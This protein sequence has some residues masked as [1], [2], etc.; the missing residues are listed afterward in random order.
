MRS[1]AGRTPEGFL[2]ASAVQTHMPWLTAN[3]PKRSSVRPVDNRSLGAMT[4]EILP[5]LAVRDHHAAG[6]T[7]FL[8]RGVQDDWP[9]TVRALSWV[10]YCSA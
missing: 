6:G 4:P 9:C 2:R 7:T 10:A 1:K 8:R 5:S 3:R